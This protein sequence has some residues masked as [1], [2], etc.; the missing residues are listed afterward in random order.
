[1]NKSFRTKKYNQNLKNQKRLCKNIADDLMST[2]HICIATHLHCQKIKKYRIQKLF[3]YDQNVC[4]KNKKK[5]RS[6]NSCK[7]IRKVLKR[8]KLFNKVAM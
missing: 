7:R 2:I 8:H 1:M 4:N 5:E 3:I 6:K